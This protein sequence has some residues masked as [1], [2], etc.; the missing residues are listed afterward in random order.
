MWW[1]VVFFAVPTLAL[2]G[3]SL[4][5]ALAPT[6]IAVVDAP[7]VEVKA[8]VGDDAVTRFELHRGLEVAVTGEEG[9][10]RRLTLPDGN[11]GWVHRETLIEV[12]VH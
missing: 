4:K 8:G 2:G 7:T 9:N 11:Q 1:G 10:W 12:E 5:W 6:R 3:T